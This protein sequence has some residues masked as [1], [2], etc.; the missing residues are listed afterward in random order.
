MRLEDDVGLTRQPPPRRRL[1]GEE[2]RRLIL[3]L[4]G[5]NV[6]ETRQDEGAKRHSDANFLVMPSQE[7]YGSPLGGHTDLLFSHPVYWLHGRAAGVPLTENIAPFGKVYHIGSPDDLMKMV[8]DE[9]IMMSMPHP[10]TKNNTGVTYS[11]IFV[12]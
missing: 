1:V 11:Q 9:D 7:Y 2:R 4:R 6:E 3:G 8:N 10:R 5:T 12:T